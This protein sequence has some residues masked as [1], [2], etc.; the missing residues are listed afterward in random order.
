MK[1]RNSLLLV[2]FIPYYTRAF[3]GNHSPRSNYLMFTSLR[4]PSSSFILVP[5]TE[6][7]KSAYHDIFTGFKS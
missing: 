2:Y 7:P 3:E 4:V 1:N 5:Y 6:L